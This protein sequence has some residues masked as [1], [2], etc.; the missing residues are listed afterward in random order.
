MSDEIFIQ[1][2][3]V[4]EA[5]A[6]IT[7]ANQV[8]DTAFNEMERAIQRLNQSWTSQAS[9]TVIGY[10]SSISSH[11]KDNRFAVMNDY[12]QFLLGAVVEGYTAAENENVRL[13]D[14]FK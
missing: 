14:A 9:G 7:H 11:F 1:T 4:A 5:A 10:F 13:A 6:H 12:S 2:D 3:K 8:I